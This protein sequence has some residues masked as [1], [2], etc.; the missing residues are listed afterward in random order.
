M[1]GYGDGNFGTGPEER[2]EGMN[3]RQ[4]ND[5]RPAPPEQLKPWYYQYWFLYP[6]FVFWPVWA[7]LIIRSPWHNGMAS[8]AVAWAMLFVGGYAI[9]YD[10]LWQDR[11]LNDFTIT[12]T[13]PGVILTV[14][15]QVLWFR[16]R[17]RVR[18]LAAEWERTGG[19]A[20]LAGGRADGDQGGAA[21]Q[22][23]SSRRGRRRRQSRG[24]RGR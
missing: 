11:A 6:V 24:R 8:G 15:T 10:Q 3:Q 17:K 13:V 14:V 1:S 20:A 2:D 5:E 12:I 23:R 9:G 4:G 22:L 7:V 18:E 19:P 21:G 16:D